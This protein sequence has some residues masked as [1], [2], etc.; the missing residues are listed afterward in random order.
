MVWPHKGLRW[1]K[2]GGTAGTAMAGQRHQGQVTAYFGC[3]A[4]QT[5]TYETLPLVKK[6]NLTCW[7]RGKGKGVS[8]P[9]DSLIIFYVFY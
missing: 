8:L 1:Q 2:T 5:G 7:G 9:S 4:C 3:A 6:V